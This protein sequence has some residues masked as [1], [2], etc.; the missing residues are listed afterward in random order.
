MCGDILRFGVFGSV[1]SG[2][3][4]S[5]KSSVSSVSANGIFECILDTMLVTAEC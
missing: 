1:D 2:L 3:I 4:F 5:Q